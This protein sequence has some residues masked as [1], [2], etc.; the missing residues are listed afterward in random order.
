VLN[1]DL[2]ENSNIF[3]RISP[4]VFSLTLGKVANKKA[5]QGTNIKSFKKQ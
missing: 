2:P 5:Y 4:Y 1:G 3:Y